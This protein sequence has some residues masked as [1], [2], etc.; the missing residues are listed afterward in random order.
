M[1]STKEPPYGLY[2]FL[3]GKARLS[4]IKHASYQ[5]LTLMS[6]RRKVKVLI[7]V[8]LLTVHKK[9]TPRMMKSLSQTTII[10]SFRN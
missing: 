8:K 5:A 9:G 1:V 4:H 2:K 10:C 3:C 7:A 6:V